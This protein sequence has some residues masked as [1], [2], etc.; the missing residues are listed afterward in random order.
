MSTY[1]HIEHNPHAFEKKEAI[2]SWYIKL[3]LYEL[4]KCVMG[5]ML[6]IVVIIYRFGSAALICHLKK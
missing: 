3:G 4:M 5:F 6:P 1:I 2:E